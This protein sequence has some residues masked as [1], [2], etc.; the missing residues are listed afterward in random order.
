MNPKSEEPKEGVRLPIIASLEEALSALQEEALTLH[1][2][3]DLKNPDKDRDTQFGLSSRSV[4]RTTVG[5]VLFNTIWPKEL[6][7]FNKP[8]LKGDLGNLILETYRIH[9]K[10]ETIDA[11]DRLKE[12]ALIWRPR[13]EFR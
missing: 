10:P 1:D 8:A 9:G 13:P 3:I 11:L 6:G 4:I 12:L 5:R 2:W 7:F